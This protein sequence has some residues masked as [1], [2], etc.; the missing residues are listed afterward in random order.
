LRRYG[1]SSLLSALATL[2]S[3]RS[4]SHPVAVGLAVCDAV[5][6]RVLRGLVPISSVLVAQRELRVA[7]VGTLSI[8]AAFIMTAGAPLWTLALGPI[9]FGV[10]HLLADVRYCIVRPGLHR[11]VPLIVAAGVPLLLGA[12]LSDPTISLAAV[13]GAGVVAN[14]STRRR[15][16]IVALA[17][18]AAVAMA[19]ARGTSILVLLHAHNLVAIGMWWAWRDRQSRLHWLPLAAFV[20]LSALLWFAAPVPGL[21]DVAPTRLG[22]GRHLGELA[23]GLPTAIGARVVLLFCFAQAVH[24]AIW[25]RMVPD[26][27]RD[28]VTTRSFGQTAR[29]LTR[30]LGRP[31][32][33]VAVVAAFVFAIWAAIDLAQARSSYLRFGMFHV[34]LELVAAALF[35]IE[36]R[37]GYRRPS[38]PR[39]TTP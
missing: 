2:S 39:K 6:G 24:Y 25:L 32:L 26:E 4:G 11:R 16:M 17:I 22:L 13:A 23:P 19:L 29:A 34:A 18:G 7:V 27:D 28:R 35:F 1:F 30:E 14:G 21:S 10:P 36:G 3:A 33:L 8:A 37:P 12:L 15:A 31:V 9:V 20:G 5:R 38:T